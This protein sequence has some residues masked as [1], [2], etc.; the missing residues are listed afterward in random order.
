MHVKKKS[1]NLPDVCIRN[2]KINLQ[3]LCLFLFGVMLLYLREKTK[4]AKIWTVVIVMVEVYITM[5]QTW[6]IFRC[7]YQRCFN[8][9]SKSAHR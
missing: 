3:S 8:I 1:R 7:L 5:D 9:G 2:V 4:E 6:I